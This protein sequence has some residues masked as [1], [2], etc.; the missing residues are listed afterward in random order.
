MESLAVRSLARWCVSGHVTRPGLF[1]GRIG[2]S[3]WAGRFQRGAL[4]PLFSGT[5]AAMTEAAA[6]IM[7]NGG[8]GA[9]EPVSFHRIR[10]NSV[11]CTI[12]LSTSRT[13]SE[14]STYESS[15]QHMVLRL[16]I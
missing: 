5:P 8:Q 3:G 12:R 10:Y 13:Y 6:D 2:A 9:A 7:E 14:T 16:F 1:G 4:T 11:L 15:V